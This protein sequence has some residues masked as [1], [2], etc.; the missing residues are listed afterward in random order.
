MIK[1][2]LNSFFK[3]K[4]YSI[5]IN[6]ERN[7]KKENL[8]NFIEKF[9]N[10]YVKVD[11]IRI[12]GQGDGGYL[13][14]NILNNINY[15]FSAGVGDISNFEKQLSNDYNIKSFMADGSIV[16]PKQKDK[17]FFFVR[18]Y[19]SSVT[20]Q[21][22]ITLSDWMNMNKKKDDKSNI[23]QMDIESSEYDVLS[24]EN[25]ETLAEFS[26]MVIEFHRF[27]NLCNP[28]FLNIVNSI[29]E[30]IYK[31]FYICH[32]HPNNVSGIYNFQNILIPSCLE[33]TFIRKNSLH[34][35]KLNE[36]VHLPHKLDYKNNNKLDN[37][38]M[39]EIWWKK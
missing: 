28:I 36:E 6:I 20:N 21:Q 25:E 2:I 16:G 3:K 31:N 18:K 38:V 10:H 24:F 22:F 1:N 35:C 39:P 4:L 29:F 17:N 11:L 7:V 8:L 32:V 33:I 19:L 27:Q 30:K 34:L 23:L 12:G 26:I 15:C 9:K 37:L 5:G 13:V 14:P